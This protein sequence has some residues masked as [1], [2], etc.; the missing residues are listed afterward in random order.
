MGEARNTKRIIAEGYDRMGWR[1][2]KDGLDQVQ[3]AAEGSG[4]WIT[5]FFGWS[6]A[7][8]GS[9][10]SWFCFAASAAEAVEGF[11]GGGL[12]PLSWRDP[13]GWGFSHHTLTTIRPAIGPQEFLE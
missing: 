6:S 10:S 1:L 8:L 5:R 2:K 9:S 3:P 12:P 13:A 4:T 7:W 11:A